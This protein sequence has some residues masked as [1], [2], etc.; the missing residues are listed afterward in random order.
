MENSTNK[1]EVGLDWA[2][3]VVLKAK[4]PKIEVT[5]KNE[6]EATLQ[7]DMALIRP[8]DLHRIAD[9]L[10]ADDIY[11]TWIPSVHLRG[12]TIVVVFK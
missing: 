8:S 11:V 3:W 7:A 6:K 1:T 2:K 12:I 4:Y 10:L 5:H 9:I